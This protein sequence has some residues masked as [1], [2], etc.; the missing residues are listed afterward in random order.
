MYYKSLWGESPAL[1]LLTYISQ[2]LLT[3]I[4]TESSNK[5]GEVLVDER[6]PFSLT[7]KLSR[8]KRIH[9]FMICNLGCVQFKKIQDWILKSERNRKRICVSLLDRSIHQDLWDYGASKEPKKSTSKENSSVPLT[10]HDPKDLRSICLG[11]ETQ[12]PSSNSFG[13]KNPMLDFLKE[14][15]P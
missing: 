4:L 14:I 1:Q 13:C 8:L 5:I 2:A 7:Q 15:H 11:K 12:N 10:H 3:K 6:L 9:F